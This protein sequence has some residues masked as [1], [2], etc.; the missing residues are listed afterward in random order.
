[1]IDLAII[2]VAG[3]GTALLPLTKS[4]PKEMLPVGGKPVVQHVVEELIQCRLNRFLFI[5]GPGKTAIED[6]FDINN[7]LIRYLR[8]NGKEDLL[9][10]LAFER[11]EAEYFYT[12]QRHQSGLGHAVLCAEP[13]VHG[14][15][16]VVAL[17]DTILGRYTSSGIV[18]RMIDLFE[19]NSSEIKGIIAFDEVPRNEVI[20]Y[21]IAK[22]K[23]WSGDFFELDDIVEKPIADETP[24]NLAVAARY[25][26]T[27]DIFDYL[28]RTEPGNDGSI[29]LTDA[30]SLMIRDHKKIL[31]V[32]LPPGEYRYDIGS[33]ESYYKAFL[34]FALHDPIYGNTL[35]KLVTESAASGLLPKRQ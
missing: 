16:F 27:P 23:E 29:Q 25:I 20:H 12:R 1:M 30:I 4:Q 34:D 22:P 24:S 18:R 2:P 6:H 11:E 17:G 32:R 10:E 5:T 26:F 19:R 14:H 8:L 28:R 7:E 13:F 3:R 9:A 15:R 33:F 21:G 31:G 35:K